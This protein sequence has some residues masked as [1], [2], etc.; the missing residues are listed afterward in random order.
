MYEIQAFEFVS[1]Q[2]RHGVYVEQFLHKKSS[3][4]YETFD[5]LSLLQGRNERGGRG[6]RFCPSQA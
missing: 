4:K 6:G 3:P 1:F 2:L 5:S